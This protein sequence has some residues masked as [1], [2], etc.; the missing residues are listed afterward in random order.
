MGRRMDFVSAILLAPLE[1]SA[2]LLAW[3]Y[4]AA[5][6]KTARA[7]AA[8]ALPVLLHIL[9]GVLLGVGM[10]ALRWSYVPAA[11]ISFGGAGSLSLL[12]YCPASGSAIG[13]WF[14]ACMRVSAT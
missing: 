9:T 1:F 13:R 14:S 6:C 3:T 10:A 5:L 8:D 2:A 11:L 12:G 4:V 7:T